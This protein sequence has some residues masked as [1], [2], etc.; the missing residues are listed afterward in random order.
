MEA[1][2]EREVCEEAVE[3]DWRLSYFGADGVHLQVV[4]LEHFA[5]VEQV[6][7]EDFRLAGVTVEDFFQFTELYRQSLQDSRVE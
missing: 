2:E 1:H 7:G 4:P 3:V 5:Q 6:V